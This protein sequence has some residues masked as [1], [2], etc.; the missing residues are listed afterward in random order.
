MAPFR[1]SNIN[2]RLVSNTSGNG[3]VIGPTRTPYC[4]AGVQ[5]TLTLGNRYC[6]GGGQNKGIFKLDESYCGIKEKCQT[7]A[8]DFKGYYICQQ[9]GTAYFVAPLCAEI[10]TS[11]YGRSSAVSVADACVGAC[12]W[13]VPSCGQLFNIG[14]NARQYWDCFRGEGYWSND[15]F[16]CGC[17]W[18]GQLAFG[19][20]CGA[21]AHKNN[22]FYVRA[23]RCG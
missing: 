11:W 8:V 12:S 23:F 17:I 5:P 14:Y 4:V 10:A 16:S 3:G 2:K 20:S 13:F 6:G 18:D 21:A 7:A 22:G 9:G 19:G 15:G 1:P